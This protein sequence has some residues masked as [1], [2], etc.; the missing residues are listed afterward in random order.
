MTY[1]VFVLC[2]FLFVR[3]RCHFEAVL[4]SF[5]FRV[6]FPIR[7]KLFLIEIRARIEIKRLDVQKEMFFSYWKYNSKFKTRQNGFQMSPGSVQTVT[8][9]TWIQD[10]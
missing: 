3:F 10:K 7:N 1:L 8:G 4:A 9:T 6:L 2:L 5:E